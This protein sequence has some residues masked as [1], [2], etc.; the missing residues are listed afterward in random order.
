MQ[1]EERG[2]GVGGVALGAEDCGV[3][4]ELVRLMGWGR[5]KGV[6]VEVEEG[7]RTPPCHVVSA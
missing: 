3:V 5:R 2:E 1:G 6:K 4:S 7:E